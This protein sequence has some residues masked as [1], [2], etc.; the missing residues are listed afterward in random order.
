MDSPGNRKAKIEAY[1]CTRSFRILRRVLFF[2]EELPR[3]CVGGI[4]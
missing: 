2:P 3:R 1:G 4:R